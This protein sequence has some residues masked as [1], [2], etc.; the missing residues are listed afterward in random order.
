MT[1]LHIDDEPT[2]GRAGVP[3]G[4]LLV[5]CTLA[6]SVIGFAA[7]AQRFGTG[8]LGQRSSAQAV[9]SRALVFSD[10]ADG[11]I[12][13][14]DAQ[15]GEELQAI[16]GSGGFVRGTIRALARQR[17]LAHVGADVPFHLIKWSDGRLTLDDSTTHSHL[18]LDAYG[19]EN[20]R[21]FELLLPV[22]DRITAQRTP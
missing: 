12:G 18:E 11:S 5:A 17:R 2:A 13:V 14:F 15:R 21:A 22:T 7:A 1:Y 8:T 6:V 20:R 10:R 19:T 3:R 4:A 9:T 16:S